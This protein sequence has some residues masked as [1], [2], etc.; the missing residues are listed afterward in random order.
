MEKERDK[1]PIDDLF[2]RKLGKMSLP[3]SADGFERLQKRMAQQSGTPIKLGLWHNPT[4]KRYMAI[5]ACFLVVCL[6]G[7]LY[8]PINLV[9][10]N[11]SV[12][13][14]RSP[15]GQK[16]IQSSKPNVTGEQVATGSTEISYV[17][18]PLNSSKVHHEISSVP[19]SEIPIAASRVVSAVAQVQ[20]IKS[21]PAPTEPATIASITPPQTGQSLEST[22]KAV[23][24]AERVLVVTIEEPAVL[25]AAHQEKSELDEKQPVVT[26]T[27][28]PAKDAKAG[29]LWQKVKQLRQGELVAKSDNTADDDQG[30][31]SRAYTGLK[32]SIEK[33]KTARQ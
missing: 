14:R 20:P 25:A 7:W 16:T 11:P 17:Q 18:K 33:G 6:F 30:L 28:K 2:A 10:K 26:M 22:V 29:N 8:W 23:P 1:Q 13:I 15:H 9:Q 27:D 12:A 21:F 4:A 24:P 32:H 5:A 19:E 31:L 3:A